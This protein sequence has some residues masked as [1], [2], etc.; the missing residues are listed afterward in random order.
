MLRR[1]SAEH[2]EGMDLCHIHRSF[3]CPLVALCVWHSAVTSSGCCLCAPRPTPTSQI[4]K[5]SPGSDRS[6]KIFPNAS[7]PKQTNLALALMERA[8]H[9]PLC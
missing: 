5:L 3:L 6:V 7:E 4:R 8:G 2:T 1:V 9:S